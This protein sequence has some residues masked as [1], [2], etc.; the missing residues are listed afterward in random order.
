MVELWAQPLVLSIPS[1]NKLPVYCFTWDQ[2]GY[3]TG[4]FSP[5]VA[6][7]KSNYN[8]TDNICDDICTT[9]RT[10]Y[11]KTI[12]Y[13]LQY[14]CINKYHLYYTCHGVCDVQKKI[15]FIHMNTVRCI[16]CGP[17]NFLVYHN[18]NEIYR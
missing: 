15:L 3:Q 18:V 16:P 4:T 5:V 17:H 6:G 11:F 14:F 1:L 10:S 2:V 7:V 12:T 8:N 9:S 13:Q